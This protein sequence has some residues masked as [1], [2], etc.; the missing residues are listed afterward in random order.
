MTNLNWAALSQVHIRPRDIDCV[1]VAGGGDSAQ[2]IC[3]TFDFLFM[4]A[5]QKK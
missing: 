1:I 5:K 4:Q 3:S 2:S